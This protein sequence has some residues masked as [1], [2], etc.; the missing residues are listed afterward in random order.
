MTPS[1]IAEVAHSANLTYCE[2]IGDF[3]QKPW[4][5]AEEWQRASTIAG[6]K[7]RLANMDAPA[8]SQHEAWLADKI[9]AGW[10]FGPEKDPQKLTHPCCVPYDELP[11]EQ[12]RKDAL[13]V[14]IVK[15]LT[16]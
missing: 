6:V 2:L 13:F 11:P 12:K 4:A 16:E 5:E 10:K 9:A 3:S 15:A 14:G 8:S 1:E 7:W